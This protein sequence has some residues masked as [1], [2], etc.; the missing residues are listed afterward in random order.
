MAKAVALIRA[1]PIFVAKDQA[2]EAL[3][4]SAGTVEMLVRTGKLKPP[5]EISKGRV[6]WLWRELQEFA[7]SRPVSAQQPGPGRKAPQ[8]AETA[9]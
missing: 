1:E 3:S 6:G 7:E 5:R 9:A 8:A 4:V 2:A